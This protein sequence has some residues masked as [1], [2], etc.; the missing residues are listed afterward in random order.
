MPRHTSP[1]T[2]TSANGMGA[3]ATSIIP[4]ILTLFLAGTQTACVTE[5]EAGNSTARP[6]QPPQRPP[7]A[8]A[9]PAPRHTPQPVITVD[10]GATFARWGFTLLPQPTPE[11]AAWK[12]QALGLKIEVR[13]DKSFIL[14]NGTRIWLASPISAG[15]HRWQIARVDF[16]NALLPILAPVATLRNSG[17]PIRR[18]AHVFLDPGHGGIDI[19]CENP[20]LRLREKELTLDVA[21]R[22]KHL[23]ERRGFRVTLSRARD[24]EVALAA[25]PAAARRAGA[26]LFVSIHFNSAGSP[27]SQVVGIETF[28][29]PP[30]GQFSTHSTR[31]ASDQATLHTPYPGH[32]FTHWNTILAYKIQNALAAAANATGPANRG[33]KRARLAVLRPAMMPAVLVECGFVPSNLEGPKIATPAHREKLA[34]GIAEGI[35]DYQNTVA[36]AARPQGKP[37]PLPQKS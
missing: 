20:R 24:V 28:T 31:N 9:K 7:V 36:N 26:D 1:R 29:L 18:P 6:I 17:I 4:L 27:G 16:D 13:R 34:R 21:N 5:A 12:N 30:R 2:Q 15:G 32:A 25:R 22:V 3:L 10:L 35:I 11:T 23:L 37:K 33:V 14:V 19:G 8:V